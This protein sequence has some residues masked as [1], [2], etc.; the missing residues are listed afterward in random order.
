MGMVT[1]PEGETFGRTPWTR[2]QPIARPL[3]VHRTAQ[4]RKTRTNIHGLSGIRTHGR[5]DQAAQGLL[6]PRGHCDPHDKQQYPT[7]FNC[8]KDQPKR[9]NSYVKNKRNKSNLAVKY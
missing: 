2:D 9:I 4:H 5:S 3:P 6:R 7:K 8:L 1:R